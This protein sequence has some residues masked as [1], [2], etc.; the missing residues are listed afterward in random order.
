MTPAAAGNFR[1][2][3][4]TPP[5][6]STQPAVT[7]TVIRACAA[8]SAAS[9]PSHSEAESSRY[10]PQRLIGGRY[11]KNRKFPG[12]GTASVPTRTRVRP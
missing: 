8:S 1:G 11:F 7:A 9:T 3:G 4:V 2:N 5:S 12:N 10:G 6:D